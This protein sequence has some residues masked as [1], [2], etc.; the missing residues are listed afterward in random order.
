MTQD[1]RVAVSPQETRPA[2][3][4]ASTG[5]RPEWKHLLVAG[6][7]VVLY[8]QSSEEMYRNWTADNTYYSHGFLVPLIS[9]A[10]AWLK[11]GELAR[12]PRDVSPWG[13]L[14]LLGGLLLVILGDSLGFRV[15]AQFAIIPV[16]TGLIILLYGLTTA[17]ILW[18]PLFFL[19]FMVPI[20]PSLTES[21]SFT[22]KNVAAEMAVRLARLVTL[23]MVREGSYIYFGTDKLLV[24]D[25]CAGLRSLISLVAVGALATY[26]SKTKPWARVV[27]LA[28]TVPIA[29]VA[30]VVRIFL[31]C[32]VGY[33]WGSEVAA[34]KFHDVSGILIYV[35]AF[36]MF[37][38]LEAYLRRVAPQAETAPPAPAPPAPA[39]RKRRSPLRYFAAALVA[40]VLATGLHLSILRAQALAP[41]APQEVEFNIPSQIGRFAQMGAD[42]TVPDHQKQYL[43]TNSILVRTY[44]A[45]DTLPVQM[46]IVYAGRTRRSLHFPEVCAT[47]SGQ[48]ILHQDTVPVG[49]LFKAK[50]LVLLDK[51]QR[52]AMLYWFKTGDTFTG[53]YF[54]NA[55]YWARNQLTFGPKSSAMIQLSAAL[56]NAPGG[57]EAAF[58]ALEEFAMKSAPLLRKAIP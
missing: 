33:F 52:I 4:P 43:E 49:F 12:A 45:P 29:V 51:D 25:V 42:G 48:E 6:V 58:A 19:V 35:V 26:F 13:F 34:G 28:M 31:L 32:V 7:L 57:E 47:G 1:F 38:A 50:R 39:P 16:L 10:I 11:R 36:L 22:L 2:E 53:N 24:G 15:F 8:W 46:I 27:L 40:L 44:R 54:L 14:W 30:N 56:P 55:Y 21:V 37:F 3:A 23:P 5:P 20:P 18:F 9:L 17:R 41:S